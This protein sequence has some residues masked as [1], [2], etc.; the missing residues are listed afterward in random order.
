[1]SM[2]SRLFLGT[3]TGGL[4]RLIVIIIVTAISTWILGLRMRRR[5]KRALGKDVENE[6]ELDSLSTWMKVEDVE[7]RNKG[8]KLS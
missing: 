3:Y 7:E 1:M 2:I 6:M 8:G 4:G 5:I